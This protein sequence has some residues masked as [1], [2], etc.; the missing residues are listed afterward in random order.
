MSQTAH[1]L[2]DGT[3]SSFS[4]QATSTAS[5]VRLP[6]GHW[7]RTVPPA[8]DLSSA[9]QSRQPPDPPAREAGFVGPDDLIGPLAF[10][11][12]A[13]R[14]RLPKSGCSVPARPAG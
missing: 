4:R 1:K 2:D 14:H 8:R 7:K 13:D 10:L 9:R 5:T 12:V 3:Q 11:V 6:A